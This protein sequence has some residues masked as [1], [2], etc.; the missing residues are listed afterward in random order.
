MP[1][2]YYRIDDHV[3]RKQEFTPYW[4]PSVITTTGS[5]PTTIT[6]FTK[7]SVRRKKPAQFKMPTNY[8]R[9]EH[10][11]DLI[12]RNV[13]AY[14]YWPLYYY[15]NRYQGADNLPTTDLTTLPS[16]DENVANRAILQARL[17]LKDQ[18]V[19]LSQ[20][21]VERQQTVDLITSTVKRITSAIHAVKRGRLPTS[22]G[23]L[24]RGHNLRQ[25]A[26]K[27]WLELQYGW[28]P[29]LSDVHGSAELLAKNDAADPGR[30]GATVKGR[31]SSKDLYFY[32]RDNHFTGS[33]CPC[34]YTCRVD[35]QFRAAVHLNYELDNPA[36]AQANSMGLLNPLE[37][38]WEELPF[39][40]VADWFYPVGDYLSLIGS[41]AGW[42]F[43]AGSISRRITQDATQTISENRD[44]S[45]NY[46]YTDVAVWGQAKK[47]HRSTIRT[48]FLNS[49]VP[50]LIKPKNP[51]SALHC[52]EAI[53]LLSKAF[54]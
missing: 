18:S 39:S 29:L 19:S 14:Y 10:T 13:Y 25:T 50:E 3:W 30:Y 41:D 51:L 21:F 9:T 33:G 32:D 46:G 48:I 36:I 20:A 23:K 8:S 35:T 6:A 31:A 7:D 4:G 54:R 37:L 44:S 11:G 1:L 24:R 53:A 17:N 22:L 43:R 27:L 2:S 5:W 47:R 45:Y 34:H 52:S 38:A 12:F 16:F 28:K 42:N 15:W 40:F 49:P 26:S